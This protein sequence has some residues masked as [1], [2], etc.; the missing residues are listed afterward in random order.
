MKAKV[1]VALNDKKG[2]KAAAEACKQLATEAKNMDYVRSADEV[3]KA[4]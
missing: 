2:A 3:L 4:L 1:H